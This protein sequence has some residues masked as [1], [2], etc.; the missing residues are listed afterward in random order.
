MVNPGTAQGRLDAHK[1]QPPAWL[2]LAAAGTGP[3]PLV[4]CEN[5]FKDRATRYVYV[6][7]MKILNLVLTER[8]SA[9]RM[10]MYKD[11]HA[12]ISVRP[13]Q[14]GFASDLELSKV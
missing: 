13:T 11:A 9:S 3:G 2:Q 4:L 12:L 6:F 14:K 1:P 8:C 5:T 10:L 7:V